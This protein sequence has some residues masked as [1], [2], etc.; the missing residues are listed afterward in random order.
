MPVRSPGI[1][2]AKAPRHPEQALRL[3]VLY[4]DG[5]RT[6][7]NSGHSPCADAD[8]EHLIL[9]QNGGGGNQLA[10][11][12]VF[13]VHP[14]PPEGPVTLVTSWLEHGAPETRAELDGNAIREA[15]R[16]AVVLW[17]DEPDAEPAGSWRTQTVAAGGPDDRRGGMAARSSLPLVTATRDASTWRIGSD[18]DVRWIAGQTTPG[19]TIA[20]AIPPV[21]DDY[22]TVVI[23]DRDEQLEK[24]DRAVVSLLREHSAGQR[25][26]LGY[27]DT[28]VDDVIFPAAPMVTLY[29]GW[30][31]VLVEAGPEQAA[32]WRRDRGMHGVLPDRKQARMEGSNQRPRAASLPG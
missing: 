19:R 22:A 23:P 1:G 26:S 25:W 28:G 5:R 14:L 29:A 20:A 9:Q 17:P 15:A 31:Y 16:R 27:L 7:T 3:G 30:R 12:Q 21:F 11:D 10:W 2:E 18:S 24:H 6:A 4:A 8:D 13:W 32:S